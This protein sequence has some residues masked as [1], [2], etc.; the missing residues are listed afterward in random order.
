MI[1]EYM[2]QINEAMATV[3]KL[4]L[5]RA[6]NQILWCADNRQ[7]ILV[8]GNGGSAAVADHWSC[9][10]TKGIRGDTSLT[11]NVRSLAQ[12]VSMITAIGNDI[13]YEE[14]FSKQIEY[15]Q[16]YHA[17]VLAISSSGSSPNIVKG[18]KAARDRNYST[19]AFVGFD[20]GE[21]VKGNMADN[22]VHVKANNYGVVED[23]HQML[24]HIIAQN[25]RLA[26]TYK[27]FNNLKL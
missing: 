21:V 8:I 16:E 1:Y 13:G 26:Y 6:R 20:G 4:T 9:D 23:C 5:L 22:I 12:N 2:G 3:D 15:C 18:L 14:I 11:P 19:L 7:Q 17:L 27:D 24:M 10:H 25:L